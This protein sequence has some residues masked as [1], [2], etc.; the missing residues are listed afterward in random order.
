MIVTEVQTDALLDCLISAEGKREA[1]VI[2]VLGFVALFDYR[3][4]HQR[5]RAWLQFDTN[6]SATRARSHRGAEG[7]KE[8]RGGAGEKCVHHGVVKAERL[9]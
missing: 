1:A 5:A 3:E 4:V 8:T 7:I 9:F 6:F 2:D